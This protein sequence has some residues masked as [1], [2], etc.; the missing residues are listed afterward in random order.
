MISVKV[1]IQPSIEND[2][3]ILSTSLLLRY[4]TMH[5]YTLRIDEV[6]S[7]TP[8]VQCIF[9]RIIPCQTFSLIKHIH[10]R[11]CLLFQSPQPLYKLPP[12]GGLA[13]CFNEVPNVVL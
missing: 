8:A 3:V 1:L 11:N 9:Q 6:Y 13:S 12:G 2:V 5:T 7:N 4:M 10:I